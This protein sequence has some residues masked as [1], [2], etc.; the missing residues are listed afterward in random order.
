MPTLPAI[1]LPAALVAVAAGVS[2]WG[3]TAGHLAL[4]FLGPGGESA[5][6]DLTVHEVRARPDRARAR[7][8][9]RPWAAKIP[10]GSST[11]GSLIIAGPRF[12]W[13]GGGD[14]GDRQPIA[15]SPAAARL[16]AGR[17][18]RRTASFLQGFANVSSERTGYLTAVSLAQTDDAFTGLVLGSLIDDGSFDQLSAERR[19]LDRIAVDVG[20]QIRTDVAY[21]YAWYV[22]Q[23]GEIVV[24]PEVARPLAKWLANPRSVTPKQQLMV[25][26]ILR[27][28]LEHSVTPTPPNQPRVAHL[29][30]L[31]EGGTD[32]LAR[33]P[34]VAWSTARAFGMSPPASARRLAYDRV[35]P[36]PSGYDDFVV[37]VR[38]L[39][40]ASGIDVNQPGQLA[41]A[42]RVLQGADL[43]NEPGRL[44]AAIGKRHRLD[45]DAQRR[46]G[47]GIATA[48]G[49]PVRIRAALRRAG[50][51]T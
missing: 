10:V 37:C 24:G 28:E 32:V 4:P 18:T 25:A 3:H 41:R 40:K 44:A 22:P 14:V 6:T 7:L 1:A 5:R 20:R 38:L 33:W 46:L 50:V 49:E 48:A 15:E 12:A 21:T 34:G 51:R 42:E 45:D 36:S 13:E 27:H 30:W 19:A 23:S 2:W 11:M 39:L 35:V 26:Y 17:S 47:A 8:S 16:S 29:T 31:E 9:R 43:E